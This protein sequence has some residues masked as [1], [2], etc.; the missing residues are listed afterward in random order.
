MGSLKDVLLEHAKN[1]A[2]SARNDKKN[3]PVHELGLWTE[4]SVPGFKPF[5]RVVRAVVRREGVSL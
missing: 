1:I 2:A 4:I 5:Y 3:H